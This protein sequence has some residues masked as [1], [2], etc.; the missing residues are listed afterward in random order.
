MIFDASKKRARTEYGV[1][2]LA[3]VPNNPKLW[4]YYA[5]DTGYCIEFDTS[6]YPFSLAKEVNYFNEIRTFSLISILNEEIN[7]IN[8][9]VTSKLSSWSYQNEWRI[10]MEG[11]DRSMG[12]DFGS[13]N[14]IHLSKNIQ[15][16]Y[17]EKIE[18]FIGKSKIII[19]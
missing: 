19:V 18:G 16:E 14:K 10:I 12:Y 3:E 13:I 5:K 15:P 17:K 1:F 2:C 6:F 11:G 4:K 9:M 8:E 7:V